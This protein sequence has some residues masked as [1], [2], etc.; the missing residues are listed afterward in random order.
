M[1]RLEKAELARSLRDQGLTH[2]EIG[3]RMGISRSYAA[4]L[5]DDPSGIKV[6]ARKDSYRGTCRFCG[7]KT[8]GCNGPDLAPTHCIRPECVSRAQRVWTRERIIAEIQ[9]YAS[10]YGRPPLADDWLLARDGYPPKS[11]VYA[12]SNRQLAPFASWADAIEAAGFPRPLPGKRLGDTRPS[13]N[14][15]LIQELRN[16][17]LLTLAQGKEI[18]QALRPDIASRSLSKVVHVTMRYACRMG[19][20]ERLYGRPASWLSTGAPRR[21]P[22]PRKVAS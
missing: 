1:T 13:V 15:T 9:R 10:E 8:T 4:E 12:S 20:A 21:K 7:A 2:K 18:V 16:R 17:G 14:G 6:R 11:A 19:Y 22:G 5:V 3:S